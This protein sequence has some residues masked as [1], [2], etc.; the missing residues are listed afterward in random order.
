MEES[1]D[2]SLLLVPSSILPILPSSYLTRSHSTSPRPFDETAAQGRVVCPEAAAEFS[3]C[4]HLVIN[5][6][7]TIATTPD[8]TKALLAM[9]KC[10]KNKKVL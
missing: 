9:R 4:T 1:Q 10:L 6:T 7:G 5:H 3:R 8:C 2:G